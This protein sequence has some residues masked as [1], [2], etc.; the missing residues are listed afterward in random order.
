MTPDL[1][2][3]FEPDKLK[4]ELTVARE[5]DAGRQLV[6]DCHTKQELLDQWFAPK[7]LTTKT[8]HMDFRAGGYW[9]YVMTTPDG[10]S[11]WN[12]L[13]YLAVDPIDAYEAMDGFCNE[14]GTVDPEMPRSRWVVTFTDLDDRT[15]VTTIVK[16]DSPDGLQK[17]IDM[18]L[19]GG[20][21]S[22]LERLDELLPLLPK[23]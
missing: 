5:F 1:R 13:D 15:L 19:E 6:W 21:A 8:K 7:G 18:G 4:G 17:A 2:F 11:F 14:S 9:H 10:Q 22:T 23:S 20:M 16:Y 12:R 3:S